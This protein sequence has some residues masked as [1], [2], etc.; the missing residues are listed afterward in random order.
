MHYPGAVHAITK[1]GIL[2]L[3]LFCRWS[4][5]DK[6]RAYV[7]RGVEGLPGYRGVYGV[8]PRPQKFQRP[9]IQRAVGVTQIKPND[10]VSVRAA[11]RW[12]MN[13]GESFVK[14]FQNRYRQLD[15]LP[16]GLCLL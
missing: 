3:G 5:F 2:A 7:F 9:T 13:L 6:F 12:V 16:S 1:V 10:G 11:R 8:N 15:R 14:V 4:G